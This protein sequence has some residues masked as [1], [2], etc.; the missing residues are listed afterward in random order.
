MW[1]GG[2]V[3]QPPA[4]DFLLSR[5][6]P[7]DMTIHQMPCQLKTWAATV[8]SMSHLPL[9][10][11]RVNSQQTNEA[12]VT[13]SHTALLKDLTSLS[14]CQQVW[15]VRMFIPNL[16]LSWFSDLGSE[17]DIFLYQNSG[18]LPFLSFLMHQHSKR[19]EWPSANTDQF[20][21]SFWSFNYCWLL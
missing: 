15:N 17:F 12:L 16:L 1:G 3:F 9:A 10:S 14:T 11:R 5:Y 4:V 13:Q 20:P 19:Q 8:S 21:L 6:N 7:E 2:Q 18:S